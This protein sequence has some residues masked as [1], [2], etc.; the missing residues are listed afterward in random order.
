MTVHISSKDILALGI[1][2]G[3][4]MAVARANK[5]RVAPSA[6]RQWRGRTY[7]SKGEMQYAQ[8]L[9]Q[10]LRAGQL[11]VVVEQPIICLADAIRYRPDFLVQYVGS[12]LVECIDFK[13]KEQ[14]RDRDI[15]KLWRVHAQV[16]LRIVAARPAKSWGGRFKTVLVIPGVI[17]HVR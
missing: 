16:P 9:D 14:Q 13:G 8:H 3:V 7:D 2:A 17:P 12:D 15:W 4:G 10:L 6:E 5:F 1:D 11:L